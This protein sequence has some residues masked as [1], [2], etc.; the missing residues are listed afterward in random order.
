MGA[1][2]S[3][4]LSYEGAFIFLALLNIWPIWVTPYFPTLDGPSH[5]Y[6]SGLLNHIFFGNEGVQEFFAI[7]SEIVPNWIGHFTMAFLL[8]LGLPAALVHKLI[9]SI[10]GFG[11]PMTFFKLSKRVGGQNNA[12]SLLSLVFVYTFLFGLGF[13]N[14][15]LGILFVLL[16]ILQDQLPVSRKGV[17]HYVILFLLLALCY[18]A[19]LVAF[20]I[21]CVYFFN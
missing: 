15:G 17:S 19:H 20:G 16:V 7:N 8:Q 9:L 5:V 12:L 21:V 11:I 14:F 18:F 6:N 2:K 10:I 4:I 13:I 1:L 3:R